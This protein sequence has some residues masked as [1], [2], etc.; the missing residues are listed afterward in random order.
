M[1]FFN[2]IVTFTIVDLIINSIFNIFFNKNFFNFNKNLFSLKNFYIIIFTIMRY[3]FYLIITYPIFNMYE[4]NYWNYD[5]V[6]FH[7]KSF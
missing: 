3:F 7:N 1:E 5:K 2:Y 4:N 6:I